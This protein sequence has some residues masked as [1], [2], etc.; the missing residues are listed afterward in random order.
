MSSSRFDGSEGPRRSGS[1]HPYSGPVAWIT[2]LL[3]GWFII[4]EWQVVPYLIK[5]AMAALP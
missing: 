1:K 5:T 3:A 2:I 4:T